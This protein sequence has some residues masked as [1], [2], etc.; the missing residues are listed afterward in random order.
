MIVA[1]RKPMDEIL[2]MLAPYKKA[3]VAGCNM[4]VAVCSAGGEKEVEILSSALR[5]AR[6]VGGGEL[7]VI[8]RTL[9]RQ[10]D[11][12]G[13]EEMKDVVQDVDVVLSMAC[14]A[15]VQSVAERY[16]KVRVFPALNTKF[17]GAN[18]EP[19]VWMER[20]AACGACMLGRTGGICPIAR[21]SKGLLNGPC[22]GPEN[23]K[24]EVD[25]E[26]DCAW[27]KIYERLKEQGQDDLYDEVE[28]LREWGDGRYGIPRKIVREDLRLN[29]EG[30]T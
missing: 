22:G 15:G 25:Q 1:E 17:I 24:C 13:V 8:E 6:N 9:T 20:C 12:E 2:G 10:C 18:I 14:G 21:C 16:P 26:V 27:V 28:P 3:L 30:K 7:T 23:G 29:E 5:L 19:G 11:P 4:C